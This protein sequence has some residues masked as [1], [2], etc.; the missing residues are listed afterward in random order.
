MSKYSKFVTLTLILAITTTLSSNASAEINAKGKLD[1]SL[2]PWVGELYASNSTEASGCT[3]ILIG[4]QWV[5]TAAHCVK[6]KE[7][8]EI[9]FGGR[10]SQGG[11]IVQVDYSVVNSTYSKSASTGDIALLHISTK[12]PF[13]HVKLP[14]TDDYKLLSKPMYS[15]GLGVNEK[16]KYTGDLNYTIQNLSYNLNKF[17]TKIPALY[18]DKNSKKYSLPCSGDSGGPLVASGKESIL[19]GIASFVAQDCSP[20]TP[21]FYT[22]V[23]KYLTWIEASKASILNEIAK[24]VQSNFQKTQTPQVVV[25]KKQYGSLVYF[26]PYGLAYRYN[27]KCISDNGNSYTFTSD[28]N[29]MQLNFKPGLGAIAC[30]ALYENSIGEESIPSPQFLI[31]A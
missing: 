17:S 21:A 29:V 3:T 11:Q 12:L 26:S 30:V 23:S 8:L 19:L 13:Y 5:L 20:T 31:G 1:K 28:V 7:K 6:G 4:D 2:Y 18:Y 16:N 10:I 9:K 15:I 22:R 14:T 27:L 25:Q 24:K